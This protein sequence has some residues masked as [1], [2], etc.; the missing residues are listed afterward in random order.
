MAALKRVI[1]VAEARTKASAA[2]S[3]ATDRLYDAIVRA[4]ELGWRQSDI[5]RALGI[6]RRWLSKFVRRLRAEMQAWEG[7]Q[8]QGQ[9]T[10]DDVPF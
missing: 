5:A 9:E 2:Y 10:D 1:A 6:D 8:D 3:K 4:K 7:Q